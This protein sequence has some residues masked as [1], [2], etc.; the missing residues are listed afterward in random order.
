MLENINVDNKGKK[1]LLVALFIVLLLVID[2]VIKIEV[3]TGMRLHESIRI[4]DWFYISFIENNGMAYGMTIINKLVL[5]IFRIV[6][7]SVL[8]Y[9]L[10]RQIKLGAR[11]FYIACLALVWAGAAGNLIDCMFY[12]L[13]FN[14]SSPYYLSYFVPF[15]QGYAPFLMGKVVDMFYF[16]LIVTTWPDWVPFWGGDAFVFFSPVFNFADS[17]IS[18]GVVLLLLFCRQELSQISLRK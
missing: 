10:C 16:P 5:S 4:T 2:Q 6:A 18:V 7:I 3:K 1:G 8:G 12:G 15:G 13:I 17:C 11:N 14:A 9:Y